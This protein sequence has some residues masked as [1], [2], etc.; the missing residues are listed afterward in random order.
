MNLALL[1]FG[2]I[3][4]A[5]ATGLL[6]RYLSRI[7]LPLTQVAVGA[8][9]AVSGLQGFQVSLEPEL[10]MLL[11]VPPLLFADGWRLPKRE[12]FQLRGQILLHAFILVLVNVLLIGYLLH[13]LRPDIPLWAAFALGSVLSPTDAVAVAAISQRVKVPRTL[14]HILQGEALLN[15]ASGLVALKFSLLASIGAFTIGGAALNVLLVSVAGAGIGVVL[16]YVYGRLRTALAEADGSTTMP[17]VLLLVLLPFGAYY[18]A[19]SLHLSGILAAV[20]AGVM[21]SYTDP[22][23][24][25]NAALRLQ[26]GNFFDLFSYVLNGI[27]FL[28]LGLQVPRVLEAGMRATQSH[29]HSG[30]HLLMLV[31][32]VTLAIL[33]IRLIWGWGEAKLARFGK[34]SMGSLQHKPMPGIRVLLAH[35]VAGIRGAVTLAAAI[36]LP[37]MVGDGMPFPARDELILI[38][39]GVIILTLLTAAVCLPVL[40]RGMPEDDEKAVEQ[41][42]AE[43]AM[44]A[45]H[46]AITAIASEPGLDRGTNGNRNK[47]VK[48]VTEQYQQRIN[49]EQQELAS[50]ADPEHDHHM[51]TQARLVGLRAEREELHRLHT[52]GEIND[53]TL[54]EL[55]KPLDLAEESL[56]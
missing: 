30:L 47:I 19:E 10:F 16:A 38:A 48:A 27:I 26:A 5:A 6:N 50:D 54:Q 42:R 45:S 35:T 24:D 17:L 29:G 44:K 13:W 20:G 15:D 55:M 7:P 18:L 28:L 36:S 4:L 2:L 56:R 34:E 25:D 14:Q 46:A 53:E 37:L 52:A 40:L 3:A 1:S 8:G 31:V 39:G 9:L 49:A 32:G 41:E 43:A 51:T 22:K 23:H 33:G 11:F 12:A 21:M